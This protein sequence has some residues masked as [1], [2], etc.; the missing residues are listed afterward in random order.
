MA[1]RH[2][3]A[4][5]D[6]VPFQN[7][8]G[9]LN[10]GVIAFGGAKGETKIAI[11]RVDFS[12]NNA[13]PVSITQATLN[14]QTM[15]VEYWVA[16]NSANYTGDV[17]VS[18][19]AWNVFGESYAI[20]PI[21]LYPNPNGYVYPAPVVVSDQAALQAAIASIPDVPGA[22]IQCT[23]GTYA[24]AGQGGA[25]RPNK[26]WITV[27]AVPGDA[28]TIVAAPVVAPAVKRMSLKAN[29][30]RYVGTGLTMD[31]GQ[32]YLNGIEA[33][34][35]DGC[36][37]TSASS[38]WNPA[39]DADPS[40]PWRTNPGKGPNGNFAVY[41]T[42]CQSN[43][44]IYGFPSCALVRGSAVNGITGDALQKSSLVVNC[45]VINMAGNQTH[46]PDVYQTFGAMD[47]VI[48]YGLTYV[49]VIAQGIFLQPSTPATT[50]VGM[51]SNSAFV[52]ILSRP[53]DP[54]GVGSTQSPTTNSYYSQIQGPQFNVLFDN[55]NTQDGAVL[56]VTGAGQNQLQAT[57]VLFWDWTCHPKQNLTPVP[58]VSFGNYK[59][60]VSERLAYPGLAAIAP[61]TV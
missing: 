32:G 44:S 4:A 57:D 23:T 29:R 37:T 31:S 30:L 51:M 47:N 48:V 13:P 58:G 28:V 20:P 15:T 14:P 46:H 11:D 36:Y 3:P 6:L 41:V 60:G 52:N 38:Q 19:T 53:N 5:F 8:S 50:P 39:P 22:T 18:A 10:I 2:P 26:N 59:I 16:I 25:N 54:K 43:H 24:I 42:N 35:F 34:W 55:W 61:A 27:E 1:T 49:N 17:I 56:L 12:I 45:T 7:F 21:T 33:V 9:N 40:N